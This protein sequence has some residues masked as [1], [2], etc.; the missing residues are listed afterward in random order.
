M[1]SPLDYPCSDGPKGGNCHP[2]CLYN[3]VTDPQEKKELSSSE[4]EVFKRMLEKYNHYSKEDRNQQDQGYHTDAQVP[5]DN[6][7]CS[8]MKEH[9]GYWQPWKDEP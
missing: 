6:K 8:Y 5:A 3:I 9:G 1:W 4:P 7:A 2:Y